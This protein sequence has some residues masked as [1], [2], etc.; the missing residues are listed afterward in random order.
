M[1]RKNDVARLHVRTMI[2]PRKDKPP[3]LARLR[4]ETYDTRSKTSQR[5]A[6]A[7]PKPLWPRRTDNDRS[8]NKEDVRKMTW[9]GNLRYVLSD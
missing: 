2:S 9:L 1:P 7:L 3:L 8:V 6:I 4:G 5:T